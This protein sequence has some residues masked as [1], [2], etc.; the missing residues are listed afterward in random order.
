MKHH[1]W[2]LARFMCCKYHVRTQCQTKSPA[3]VTL[4]SL[5]HL[6]G[7]NARVNVVSANNLRHETSSLGLVLSWESWELAFP[8]ESDFNE[9]HLHDLPTFNTYCHCNAAHLAIQI[10][11]V[12]FGII[13]DILNIAIEG[14]IKVHL[15]QK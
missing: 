8:L 2:E 10:G 3:F 6:C 4:N 9:G 7:T 1:L 14:F 11:C 5:F 12:L 13:I 15:F